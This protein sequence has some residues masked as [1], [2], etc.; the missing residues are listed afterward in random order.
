M[1]LKTIV[2]MCFF[3]LWMREISKF[4]NRL[5]LQTS[6]MFA[7]SLFEIIFNTPV[8]KAAISPISRHPL[9][10]WRRGMTRYRIISQ[11]TSLATAWTCTTPPQ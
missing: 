8:P 7:N 5:K 2:V 4:E 9:K 3:Y 11:T 1:P 6:L 10:S